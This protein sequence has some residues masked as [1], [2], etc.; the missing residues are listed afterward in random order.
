MVQIFLFTLSDDE[1]E[2]NIAVST[3]LWVFLPVLIYPVINRKNS[4]YHP[5]IFVATTTKETP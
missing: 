3:P 2:I 5:E 4:F 1:K